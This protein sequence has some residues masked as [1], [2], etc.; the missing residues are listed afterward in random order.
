MYDIPETSTHVVEAKIR[1]R[2]VEITDKWEISHLMIINPPI[3]VPYSSINTCIKA[4][5]RHVQRLVG[6]IPALTTPPGWDPTTPVDIIIA[7]DG[8]V[9]LGCG[10]HNWVI[11]TADEDILI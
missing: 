2:F 1:S 11:A 10:Y 8:S 5:P 7:K 3:L 9:T 6:D 4:L